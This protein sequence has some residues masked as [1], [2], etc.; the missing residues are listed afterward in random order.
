MK[1]N[2]IQCNGTADALRLLEDAVANSPDPKLR[3]ALVLQLEVARAFMPWIDHAKNTMPGGMRDINAYVI[4]CAVA[5]AAAMLAM[6]VSAAITPG[7]EI[8]VVPLVTE[9]VGAMLL[10]AMNAPVERQQS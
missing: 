4:E 1:V 7:S 8:T 2:H 6:A 10:Q 3:G 9:R 5:S